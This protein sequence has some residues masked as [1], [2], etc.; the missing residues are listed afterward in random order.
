[1]VISAKSVTIASLALATDAPPRGIYNIKVRARTRAMAQK[2]PS[3]FGESFLMVYAVLV[4][5]LFD[6]LLD[7]GFE[8]ITQFGVVAQQRLGGVAALGEFGTIIGE[9]AATLLDDVI[10]YAEVQ[11]FLRSWRC[12][13]QT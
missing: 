1:M 4:F 2:K 10:L 11:E 6:S 3:L 12:L 8:F 9:P 5:L 13:R 7:K